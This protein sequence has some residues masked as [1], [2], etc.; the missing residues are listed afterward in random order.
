MSR[1]CKPMIG[2]VFTD[3]TVLEFAYRDDKTR[4]RYFK[5]VCSC[6]QF[7]V[8]AVYK[9]NGGLVKRCEDCH[10]TLRFE[11]A[12][13]DYYKRTRDKVGTTRFAWRNMIQ[14]CTNPNHKKYINYGARGITVCERWKIFENFL[15]DMGERPGNLQI[16]R[17]DNNKGYSPENCRWTTSK[18]NNNN[19]RAYRTSNKHE[20]FITQ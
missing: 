1:P 17:I 16:D 14:R 8:V 5:C 7:R 4:A 10:K 15:A 2:K 12:T 19:K 6:G 9:L 18:V 13:S 20:A 3:L 11:N